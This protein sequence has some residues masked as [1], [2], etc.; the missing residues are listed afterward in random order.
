MVLVPLVVS[1]INDAQSKADVTAQ[2]QLL[3]RLAMVILPAILV[4]IGYAV[5]RRR[6][7]IDEGM[8]ARIVAELDA[9]GDLAVEGDAPRR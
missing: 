4:A 8:H 7:V 6:F 9:R 2:G 3:L 5:W 1:G